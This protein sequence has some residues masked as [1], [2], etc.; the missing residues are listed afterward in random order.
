LFK[1]RLQSSLSKY[2]ENIRRDHPIICVAQVHGNATHE[3]ECAQHQ[4]TNLDMVVVNLYPVEATVAKGAD[5]DTCAISPRF[6]T[7]SNL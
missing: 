2:I 3:A 5:F 7:F 4:I 1:S 6:P